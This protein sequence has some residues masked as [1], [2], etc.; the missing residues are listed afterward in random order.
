MYYVLISNQLG[1]RPQPVPDSAKM[2]THVQIVSNSDFPCAIHNKNSILL[3]TA[4]RPTYWIPYVVGLLLSW[5][6][7]QKSCIANSNINIFSFSPS[8]YILILCICNLLFRLIKSCACV[9]YVEHSWACMTGKFISFGLTRNFHHG[10]MSIVVYGVSSASAFDRRLCLLFHQQAFGSSFTRITFAAK[11][12][13]CL[14]I[15][16]FILVDHRCLVKGLM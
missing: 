7:R 15:H 16:V 3:L 8:I 1:A 11:E 5:S 4:W 14:F 6:F 2:S 10:V 13:A 9:T 12:C